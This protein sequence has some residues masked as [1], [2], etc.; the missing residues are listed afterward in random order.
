MQFKLRLKISTK[1]LLIRLFSN[2]SS[3][4]ILSITKALCQSSLAPKKGDFLPH[5]GHRSLAKPAL[6]PP[7]RDRSGRHAW[8]ERGVQT[9]RANRLLCEIQTTRVRLKCL[10]KYF[11]LLLHPQLPFGEC[12]GRKKDR[13][14]KK[15]QEIIWFR[16][17][18]GRKLVVVNGLDCWVMTFFNWRQVLPAE[19]GNNISNLFV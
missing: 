6:P 17:A 16:E 13:A 2:F 14:Y 19:D 12:R 10:I 11:K 15:C 5:Q 1:A 8:A 18:C 3:A 9:C 4:N 7:P